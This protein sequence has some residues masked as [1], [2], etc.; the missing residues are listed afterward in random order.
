[1]GHV[2]RVISVCIHFSLLLHAFCSLL[3]VFWIQLQ[4]QNKLGLGT[5]KW[6]DVEVLDIPH[7]HI[8][9][10]SQ[11]V[12][13]SYSRMCPNYK[14]I[15]MCYSTAVANQKTDPWKNAHLSFWAPHHQA[16]WPTMSQVAWSLSNLWIDRV[17][18][19]SLRQRGVW[20]FFQD[21]L[22]PPLQGHYCTELH[23]RVLE[24]SPAP[25]HCLHPHLSCEMILKVDC[26]FPLLVI[27]ISIFSCL[28]VK[29]MHPAPGN[30]SRPLLPPRPTT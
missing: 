2:S 25:Q 1:M 5:E 20:E 26:F 18:S 3:C 14:I 11:P 7:S 29:S 6:F 16:G 22:G 23:S 10:K 13:G 15:V 27:K 28:T 4:I 24:A 21:Q 30:L 19:L 12:L 9:L 17:F 8:S